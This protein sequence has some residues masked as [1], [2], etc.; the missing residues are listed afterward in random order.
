MGWSAAVPV[1][2]QEGE[3]MQQPGLQT[4][5]ISEVVGMLGRRWLVILVTVVCCL[6]LG[7]ALGLTSP[8]TYTATAS[9]TVSPITTNPFSSAAVNQQINITTERA[10]LSSGEVASIAA[11][12]LGEKVT[13][14]TLQS[15]TETAAPS[16]SQILEVSVTLP[17]AK[18]AADQANAL[19]KAYLQ[20]RSQGAAEVAAGY[21]KQIDVRIKGLTVQR[22][23]T[24]SQLQQLQDLK[25]Q[26][27]SLTLAPASPG[28]VIG[29]AALPTTSSSMDAPV[30]IMAGAMGGLLL[31]MGLALLRERSDPRVRYAVRQSALFE[32]ELVML[33]DE[34]QESVR[35]LVRTIRRAGPKASRG[36]TTFV[37]IIALPGSGPAGLP[38]LL[39]ELTR[40][41]KL[42]AT[43]INGSGVSPEAV[44]AGWPVRSSTGR[45]EN[46]DIVY[47]EINEAVSGTRLADL[48]DRMDF[49]LVAAGKSTLQKR[50]RR[51]LKLIHAITADRV[52][53]VFYSPCPRRRKQVGAMQTPAVVRSGR[54]PRT[55]EEGTTLLVEEQRAAPVRENEHGKRGSQPLLAGDLKTMNTNEADPSVLVPQQ[56]ERGE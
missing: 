35:W 19:A 6:A 13:P 15:N 20:F 34:D 31:G 40:A 44:D 22:D 50:L 39:A 21:I 17:N 28:R 51:T 14:G 52:T 29:Y 54:D 16:G 12:E 36:S 38:T 47:V 42:D 26:R 5:R 18:K 56:D 11:K 24:D 4:L 37:G 45:W 10:I 27:T 53:P 25:Q 7:L 33:N 2:Q 32:N 1:A 30:F 43:A 8:K 3:M 48:A 46:Q 41:H 49:I 55:D 9:L 23:L